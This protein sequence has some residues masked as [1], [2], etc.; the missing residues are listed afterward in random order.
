MRVPFNDLRPAVSA[1]LPE[2]ETAIR[3]V[4]QSGHF[5]RGP[6]TLQFEAEFAAYCGQRHCVA[7]ANGT[8]ALTIAARALR[9]V[10]AEVPGNSVW[11]T[12]EGL[13]RG[14]SNIT[15][16][17]VDNQGRL[18]PRTINSLSVP[19]PLYGRPPS[20]DEESCALIDGAHAT[21][22]KPSNFGTTV[23]WSF[24]PTKTLGSLGDAGA[25]TTNNA[26]LADRMRQ[27][28]GRDDVFREPDQ[29]VSRVS[30]MQAAI[31]RVKL[32]HLDEHIA[33]RRSVADMY[34]QYLPDTVQ[35]IYSHR[36]R[37]TFHLFVIRVPEGKRDATIETLRRMDIGHK[38]HFPTPLTDMPAPW[39]RGGGIPNVRRWCDTVL[40]LPLFPGMTREE[41][42]HVCRA[43][44]SVR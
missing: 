37:N 7:V 29:I 38:V 42:Q 2:L 21:G 8:D 44:A 17:D 30:E 15:I 32:R 27:L 3:R 14:G 34:F 28:A 39:A 4:M 26:A 20:V 19:V 9:L 10:R 33:Q 6:E 31:L 16:V 18:P 40:S 12:P 22:W 25:I 43:L 36:E 41:V 5:L 1:I 24:Y 13:Y 35:H 11:C 23:A